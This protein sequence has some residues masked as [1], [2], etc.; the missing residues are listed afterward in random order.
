MKFAV[1]VIGSL[2]RPKD[3]IMAMAPSVVDGAFSFRDT[4][5][6]HALKSR[7]SCSPHWDRASNASL[8]LGDTKVSDWLGLPPA[9]RLGFFSHRLLGLLTL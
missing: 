3:P 1:A 4:D 9:W 8:P 2:P 5:P 6:G 7:G